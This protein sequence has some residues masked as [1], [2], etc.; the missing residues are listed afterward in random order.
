VK[1]QSRAYCILITSLESLSVSK[2]SRFSCSTSSSPSNSG[3]EAFLTKSSTSDS[4]FCSNSSLKKLFELADE[5]KDESEGESS[6]CCIA[7]RCF[8]ETLANSS[9]NIVLMDRRMAGDD[10]GNERSSLKAGVISAGLS[11]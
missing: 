11:L 1:T 5:L 6:A 4:L 8:E 10:V 9:L 3:W 7:A 2:A